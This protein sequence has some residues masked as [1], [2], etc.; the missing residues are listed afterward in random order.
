MNLLTSRDKLTIQFA[1]PAYRVAEQFLLRN[2]G[3][4]HFQTW[5][6]EETLSRVE[7]ADVLV[8][9]GFWKDE[10]LGIAHNLRYIQ[11]ISAGY[12]QFPLDQLDARDIRLANARGV[13]ADAVA[14]MP[15]G[16]FWL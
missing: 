9:S 12:E 3:V 15:W 1:H 13:N 7:E 10:L 11:A 16:L 5:T 2:T 4:Q 8:V 14:I 6:Y